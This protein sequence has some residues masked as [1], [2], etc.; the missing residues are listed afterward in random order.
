MPGSKSVAW[1]AVGLL[2]AA[3]VSVGAAYGGMHG[4]VRLV[5]QSSGGGDGNKDIAVRQVTVAPVRAH[6]GEPIRVDVVIE[7][8]AEGY[9]T[10]PLEISANG[11]VVAR[12][13]FTFGMSPGERVYHETLTWDTRG[14]PPGEY[15]IR[16]G[17]FVWG[18]SSPSDNDLEVKEALSLAAPGASF[19]GGAA[20]GGS[21]TA[22]DPRFV[23]RDRR[24]GGESKGRSDSERGRGGAE[25]Y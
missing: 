25:G 14:V 2:A 3:A 23:N 12:K 15:R 8:K 9:E 5:D 13:L 11:K 24:D 17:A 21:A 19:P 10:V 16:A 7:S 18:D 22:T 20:P 6:T 1:F 4:K